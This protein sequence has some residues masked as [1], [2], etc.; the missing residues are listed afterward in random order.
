[1]AL[2]NIAGGVLGLLIGYLAWYFVTRLKKYTV[3]GFVSIVGALAGGAGV[4]LLAPT[5]DAVLWYLIG[6]FG[7][8]VVYFFFYYQSH[9]SVPLF[10]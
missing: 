3:G 8:T 9:G 4:K 7:G 6:L 2:A 1:M 5:P 10:K